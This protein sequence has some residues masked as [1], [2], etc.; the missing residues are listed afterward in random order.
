MMTIYDWENMKHKNTKMIILFLESIWTIILA[1]FLSK[2]NTLSKYK[3]SGKIDITLEIWHIS[4]T[5]VG[6]SGKRYSN[7]C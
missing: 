1:V 4:T 3:N 5:I 7:V 6:V 2:Q